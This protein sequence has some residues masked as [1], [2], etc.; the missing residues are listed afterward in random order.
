[1]KNIETQ[2]HT[3][4]F[5]SDKPIRVFIRNLHPTASETEIKI[6][7]KEIGHTVRNV[8]SVKHHQTKISSPMFF[9][10]I[11][12]SITYILHTTV[13]IEEPHKKRQILQCPNCQRYDHTRS[14]S[15]HPPLCVEFEENHSTFT[16]KKLPDLLAKCGLCQGAHP[17]NYKGC[18][19]Y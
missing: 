5:Q 16:F 18:T 14:Y 17:A 19:I 10:D 13:K 15:A 2:F 3:Y 4:Q 1:L 7:L 8:T 9:V 12:P 6:A 11:D